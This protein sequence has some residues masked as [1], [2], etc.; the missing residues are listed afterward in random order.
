MLIKKLKIMKKV[1]LLITVFVLSTITLA[2]EKDSLYMF[3]VMSVS[4]Y[5]GK[6][7]VYEVHNEKKEL[8]KYYKGQY[9]KFEIELNSKKD[10][11]VEVKNVGKTKIFIK[12]N[13]EPLIV[14]QFIIG[15]ITKRW[16]IPINK[17]YNVFIEDGTFKVKEIYK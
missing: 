16:L 1:L 17:E 12:G 13:N 15:I 2:T 6:I 4:N 9:K 11:Y 5:S 3:K 14:N 10:Y 7:Y 8:I